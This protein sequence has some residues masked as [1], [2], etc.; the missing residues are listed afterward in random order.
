MPIGR[1]K[2]PPDLKRPAQQPKQ[3]VNGSPPAKGSSW[4]PNGGYLLDDQG[5]RISDGRGGWLLAR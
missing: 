4:S 5:K 1:V 3:P 2:V